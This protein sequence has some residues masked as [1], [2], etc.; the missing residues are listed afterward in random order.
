MTPGTPAAA[1]PSLNRVAAGADTDG[2]TTPDGPA[3]GWYDDGATAGV[4]RWFD[5]TAWTEHTRPVPTPS[6]PTPAVAAG[7]VWQPGAQV[8]GWTAP[9]QAL[10]PAPPVAPPAA[11]AWGGGVAA[12]SAPAGG[13]PG[14][15]GASWGAAGGAGAAWSAGP[16]PTAY[17]A[18][19]SRVLA[20]VIDA[21][22]MGVPYGVG[23]A[24]AMATAVPGVDASGYPTPQPTGTGL[25]V[26]L[27]G[28]AIAWGLQIW[29]RY[30]RTARTGQSLGK[31][32]LG[33]RLVSQET[34]TAPA[35]WLCFGRDI[36]HVLDSIAFYLGY[37]WPLWDAQRQTFADK[38]ARTVVV[39]DA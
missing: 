24:V 30:V 19:W 39:R 35:G 33:I 31:Q 38:A 15:P 25:A 21:L 12:G 20:Y 13:W 8:G 4:E 10:A 6:V 23:Y 28:V 18:W 22:V 3:A 29:N 2:M 27:A 17:A 9:A 1:R 32:A 26:L 7:T 5:G 34:G 36:A 14:A 11:P 37:L 16:A